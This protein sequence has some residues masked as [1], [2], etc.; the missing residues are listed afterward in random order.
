MVG[1]IQRVTAIV[2]EISTASDEQ[3]AG[4]GQASTA[5]S[6]MDSATQQNAALVEESAA[7]ARSLSQQAKEL[8]LAV[9]VFH[10]G[11]PASDFARS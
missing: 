2:G 10:L 9:S 7:S 3:R 5:V 6:H 8:V 4:V 1:A 11:E